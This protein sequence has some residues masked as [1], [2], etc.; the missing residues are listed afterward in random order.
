MVRIN[1]IKGLRYNKNKISNLAAV[2]TPPYDVIDESSQTRY[3]AEHPANIIRLELGLA[4]PQDTPDNDRYTRAYKYLHKWI[5]DEILISE[6]KPALYYYQQHFEIFGKN[7][8]RS[9]IICGLKA[10]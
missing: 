6:D 1:P 9:G 2:V 7:M 3:Y 5:E 8:V 10:V 4:F